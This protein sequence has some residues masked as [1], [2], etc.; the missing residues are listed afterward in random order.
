MFKSKTNYK[1][2]RKMDKKTWLKTIV[3]TKKF[4]ILLYSTPIKLIRCYFHYVNCS[5]A[6]TYWPKV[7]C[8][9]SSARFCIALILSVFYVDL[10][11]YRWRM[12][13]AH[14]CGRL[15]QQKAERTLKKRRLAAF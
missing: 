6:Y 8:C 2:K 3:T 11:H 10:C 4:Q 15:L 12:Y 7:I 14:P 9:T 13:V 5:Y 1:V